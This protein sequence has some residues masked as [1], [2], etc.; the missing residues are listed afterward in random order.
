M[1]GRKGKMKG[2]RKKREAMDMGLERR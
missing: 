1:N 2:R